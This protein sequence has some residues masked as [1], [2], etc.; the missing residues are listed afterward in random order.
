[1]VALSGVMKSPGFTWAD[2]GL[3]EIPTTSSNA[4]TVPMHQLF[5]SIVRFIIIPSFGN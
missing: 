1:L 4:I 2:A 5:H 3:M